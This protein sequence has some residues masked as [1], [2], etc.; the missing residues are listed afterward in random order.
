MIIRLLE[1]FCLYYILKRVCKTG[2][3]VAEIEPFYQSNCAYYPGV[4][5]ETRN[6]LL[7]F[8]RAGRAFGVGPMLPG[9]FNDVGLADIDLISWFWYDKGGG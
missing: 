2:G 1:I 4:D 6:L 9:L 7:K 8:S 3:K 5:D